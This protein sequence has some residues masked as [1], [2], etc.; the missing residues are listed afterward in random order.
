[1]KDIKLRTKVGIALVLTALLSL[2]YYLTYSYI[3]LY[4]IKWCKTHICIELPSYEDILAI[5]VAIVGLYFVVT[6]LEEWKGQYKFERAQQTFKKVREV[7]YGLEKL[8]GD[9]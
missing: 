9:T 7:C 5:W 8:L 3:E 2:I 4:S 1:M 6:S